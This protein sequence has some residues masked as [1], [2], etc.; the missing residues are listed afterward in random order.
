MEVVVEVQKIESDCSA[1]SATIPGSSEEKKST[2]VATK[3]FDANRFQWYLI[4][5]PTI[6][7]YAVASGVA[8]VSYTGKY[9]W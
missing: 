4:T 8:V 9:T 6:I 7:I 3:E 5:Y 1:S 2:E